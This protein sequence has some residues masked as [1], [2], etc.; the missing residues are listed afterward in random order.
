[1]I[2]NLPMDQAADESDIFLSASDV[3]DADRSG[4]DFES[5]VWPLC[6]TFLFSIVDSQ[7]LIVKSQHDRIELVTRP[8]E[9]QLAPAAT[10]RCQGQPPTSSSS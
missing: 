10:Q 3:G 7:L 4:R 2:G 5:Q 1:M 9:L 8:A 6:N